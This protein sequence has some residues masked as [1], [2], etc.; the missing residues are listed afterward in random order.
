MSRI[1]FIIFCC[2]A[3][4]V[5]SLHA[6]P[7]PDKVAKVTSGELREAKVSW[8]GF[9]PTDSTKFLRAAIHSKVPRLIVD[10][11][12]SAWITG[13]LVLVDNQEIVFEEG[14]ELLA[15]AGLFLGKN[16][17]LL[18]ASNT[19][20][21]KL[22]GLGNGA[23]LRMRKSDYHAEPYEKSEW[24]HGIFLRSVENV[25]V[26]NLSIVSSGGDGIYLGVA[27][28]GIPCRN[29]TIKKVVCDDNNRQGISVISADK[30]LIEDCVLKNTWG[31]A[32]QA[33]IDFEPNSPNEQLTDCIVRRCLIENNAG[34]GIV[35]ALKYLSK[36]PTPISIRIEDCVVKGNKNNGFRH[37]PRDTNENQLKGSCEV[38]GCRFEDNH[39]GG[40]M[41]DPKHVDASTLTMKDTTIIN[42]GKDEKNT[43][44]ILM[45]DEFID[46]GGVDFGV[47]RVTDSFDRPPFVLSNRFGYPQKV[48]GTLY[49]QRGE[50][51]EKIEINDAWFAREYPNMVNVIRRIPLKE[52]APERF[53]PLEKANVDV[54]TKFPTIWQ[55][56][57]GAYWLYAEKGTPIR[58][59]LAVRQIGR[60]EIKKSAVALTLPDGTIRRLEIPADK[61][62]DFEY[63]LPNAPETG[64]YRLVVDVGSHAVQM[65]RCNQTT[66]ISAF[67]RLALV[68]TTGTLHLLVPPG[69]Q[70]FG[71]RVRGEQG[72]TVKASIIDPAG[73][74]AWTEDNITN[75]VQFNRAAQDGKIEGLWQIVLDRPSKGAFEDN[76]VTILGLPPLLGLDP[77]QLLVPRSQ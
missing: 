50:K 5:Q 7:Q 52:P 38:I 72:E 14:V 26:E 53:V 49:L 3:S 43:P 31:T 36:S 10:K 17:S 64:V 59:A 74:T 66:V 42:C 20:N 23:V 8:W 32:P 51:T 39:R 22:L 6:A 40:I 41:I 47:I 60:T 1:C 76:A 33:G 16:E 34:D 61:I 25:T 46:F 12:A 71:I 24:R 18:T 37:A 54:D 62:K 69:T 45:G 70:E 56:S 4:V 2:L 27:T 35:L 58:F 48:R 28:R 15:K 77:K 67:P 29:V 9:D 13:P 55:R 75:V 21:L 63:V 68:H 11:Q 65:L 73:Q 44:I 30:L 57:R 19:K